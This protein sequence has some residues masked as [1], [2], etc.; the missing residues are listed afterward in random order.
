MRIFEEKIKAKSKVEVEDTKYI[1]TDDLDRLRREVNYQLGCLRCNATL[2]EIHNT[3][4]ETFK[5]MIN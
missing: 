3:V 1:N 2:K 4:N 5:E